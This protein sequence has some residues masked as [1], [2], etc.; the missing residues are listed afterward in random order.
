MT[1][2]AGF[3]VASAVGPW[4]RIG[5]RFDGDRTWVGGV[6][7]RLV[8]GSGSGLVA[9]TLLG[10]PSTPALIDGLATS[11]VDEVVAPAW[12]QPL[13]AT[14]VDHVVLRTSSLERTC[15]AIERATGEPL[16]RVREVG[17]IRQGFHRLGAVIA[18]VVESSDEAPEGARFWGFVLVVDDVHEAVDRLGP[19]LIGLPR[20]A[21]QPGRFIASFHR[22][23]G[24]GLPVA[25]MTPHVR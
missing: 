3:T 18:E 8:D 20:P 9:W 12:E 22:D 17:S 11:Y 23:A 5:L 4:E 21:V 13:A 15:R 25:L 10:S 6:E 2:V 16:R 24:L 19:E 14:A 1:A 7:I